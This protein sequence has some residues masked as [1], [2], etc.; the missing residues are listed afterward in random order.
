[1]MADIEQYLKNERGIEFVTLQTARHSP[2][3]DF[4]LK[5]DYLPADDNAFFMKGLE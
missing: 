2:V 1:M 5:N 4:Y 3:Y